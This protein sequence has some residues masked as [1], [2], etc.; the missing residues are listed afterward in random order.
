MWNQKVID[1]LPFAVPA[2]AV[3]LLTSAYLVMYFAV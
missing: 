3:L 2:L 1:A